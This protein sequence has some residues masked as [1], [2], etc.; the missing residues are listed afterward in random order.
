[1][2]IDETHRQSQPLKVLF[3][4]SSY[5]RNREDNA[6]IFLH[7]LARHLARRGLAVHVL[8]PAERNRKTWIQDGVTVHQFPY[9]F[10][11]MQRLTYGSGILHNLKRTPWLWIE[12]PFFMA[13]MACAAVRLA[14]R[15]K[16][17][18]IHAHWLVPQ[19]LIALLTKLLCGLPIVVTAHGSDAFRLKAMDF[20]K[21]VVLRRSDAWTANSR[22]TAE[23]VNPATASPQIIPMGVDVERFQR[24]DRS[25]LR[26]ELSIDDLVVLFVGRLVAGKGIDLLLQA[27][28]L[29]PAKLRART[30]F[31]VVGDGHDASRLSRQ[32]EELLRDLRFRFWGGVPN[33][34]LPDFYAAA[35]L[36]VAPA[37]ATEG[38]GV[39][40]VEAFAA[41][42]C[43]LA[44][45]VGGIQDVVADGS[46][47]KLVE[48]GN[49]KALAGAVETLLVDSD[50]RRR[51]ADEG[52]LSAR[53]NYAWETI[54]ARFEDLYR[55]VVRIRH[56]QS[57]SADRFGG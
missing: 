2:T 18:L 39:V 43:V 35:D 20:L 12:V 37:S 50:L 26:R 53:R 29:L 23:A 46:T 45:R 42:L 17:D 49:S 16:P 32:S 34:S 21:H 55:R 13:A 6:G 15:E 36:L 10:P 27:L 44:T 3:L 4:T 56:A 28:S 14:R 52:F 30:I 8:A 48:P 7:H 51:L 38:Q 19:G 9:F 47:G 54:A 31:W 33:E 11:S 5:P 24:C 40:L 22:A 1:M 57:T 41:R 25:R